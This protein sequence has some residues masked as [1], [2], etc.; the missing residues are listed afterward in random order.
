MAASEKAD[1]H[2]E[3]HQP[4]PSLYPTRDT[5]ARHTTTIIRNVRNNLIVSVNN[6]LYNRTTEMEHPRNTKEYHLYGV[7]YEEFSASVLKLNC[8]ATKDNTQIL[9]TIV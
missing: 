6:R 3:K 1:G 5:E 2:K 9:T 4:R 8:Y 7:I